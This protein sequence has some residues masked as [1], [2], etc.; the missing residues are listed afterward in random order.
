MKTLFILLSCFFLLSGFNN[1][2]EAQYKSRRKKS[3]KPKKYKPKKTKRK[4]TSYKKPS[5]NKRDYKKCLEIRPRIY[6]VKGMPFSEAL[7]KGSL[8]QTSVIDHLAFFN[9]CLKLVEG[10]R[11]YYNA[12]YRNCS[13]ST[14]R[15]YVK[16]EGYIECLTYMRDIGLAKLGKSTCNPSGTRTLVNSDKFRECIKTQPLEKSA[17]SKYRWCKGERPPAK[18]QNTQ[19]SSTTT[20]YRPKPKVKP[21]HQVVCEKSMATLKLHSG[22]CQH[23][24]FAD[25]LNMNKNCILEV[26]KSFNIQYLSKN[27]Y[28]TR[29]SFSRDLKKQ[30]AKIAERPINIDNNHLQ[31]IN[32]YYY[33][34]N[35]YI[36]KDRFGGFSAIRFRESDESAFIL[37]D[38]KGKFGRPRILKAKLV[39]ENHFF[40][41]KPEGFIHLNFNIPNNPSARIPIDPEGLAIDE[42]NNFIISSETINKTTSKTLLRVFSQTG[43][44]SHE[45]ATP[46]VYITEKKKAT[47]YTYSTHNSYQAQTSNT[48]QRNGQ[49]QQYTTIHGVRSNKGIEAL[50]ISKDKQKLYFGSEE[51]LGQERNKSH[52]RLSALKKEN[53][54]FIEDKVYLYPIEKDYGLVELYEYSPGVLFTLERKYDSYKKK[55]TSRIYKVLLTESKVFLGEKISKN[56]PKLLK[57]LVLDLDDL[58]PL[59]PPGLQRIDNIEGMSEGPRLPNGNKTLILISDNNFSSHQKTQIIFLELLDR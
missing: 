35:L 2:A 31:F 1:H 55:V 42:N 34:S 49:Q 46:E 53:G 51:P 9:Q 22:M 20:Y 37:S 45:I 40:R 36:D 59:L 39:Y 13:N 7:C 8:I 41:P 23:R 48:V 4:K 30:C 17:E 14:S 28:N 32:S 26:A 57:T 3:Y 16:R 21:E 58:L 19:N 24:D 15:Q 11:Y 44:L 27:D 25:T 5:Y 10:L 50:A 38:D 6:Q 29:N 12:P 52:I 33:A 18:K 47:S 54:T 56:S 43:Q